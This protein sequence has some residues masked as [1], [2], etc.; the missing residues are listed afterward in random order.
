METFGKRPFEVQE[1]IWRSLIEKA[2][3]TE[4]GRK[5]RFDTIRSIE[6]FQQRIPLQTYEDLKPY[7]DRARSGEKNVLWRGGT[8]WFAKSSGT[9]GNKSKFIPVTAEALAGCHYRGGRDV[10]AVYTRQHP[11]TGVFTGKTLTLGGSHRIDNPDSRTFYGD[12]S[13]VMIENMPRW[14][15]FLRTPPKEIALWSDFDKKVEKIAEIAVRQ[16]VVSFAGVPSWNMVL[17]KR[18]LACTGKNN[19]MEIWPRME[20]FIHGGMSFLPYRE[21]YRHLF[22]SDSMHYLE[23][24]NASEGFFAL[25]DDPRSDDMLLMLDYH[26]FFEFI[27][28]DRLGEEHPP[29]LTVDEVETGKNYAIVIS[30]NNGLWRYLIGDTVV[31]TSLY[32]HKIKISGRTRQFINAF[33]EEVIVDN[34]E[35]ALQ[36]ACRATGAIVSEY[37]AGPVYMDCKTNGAHQWI[38][39]FDAPPDSTE[40]FTRALDAALCSL[41]SD[42]EAKRDKD[43]TLRMPIVHVAPQGTFYNWMKSRGK[44]GGQNKVPRLSNDRRYLDEILS[45]ESGIEKR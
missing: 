9:T 23:T 8:H 13:A 33:G 15:N 30:A 20:L 42:Y 17:M 21:Q 27:P 24:Y 10:L 1:A 16:Q 44:L 3:G 31:F 45:G 29:A 39:E 12:L 36:E 28:L 18:I 35:K 14:A 7:I 26:V 22:P 32:P 37:T 40:K 4:W 34:A 19:M 11:H 38:I 43:V 25:Q 2:K 5:Y 6:D 41:N